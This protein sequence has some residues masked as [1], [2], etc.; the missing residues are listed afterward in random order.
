MDDRNHDEQSDPKLALIQAAVALV[1]LIGLPIV[2]EPPTTPWGV[3]GLVTASL[4]LM[5]F[6]AEGIV[7]FVRSRRRPFPDSIIPPEVEQIDP[8]QKIDE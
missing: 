4:L 3:G 6:C 2:L 1:L 8:K 5:I 7:R